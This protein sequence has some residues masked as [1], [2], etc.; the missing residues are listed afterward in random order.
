LAI[1]FFGLALLQLQTLID[2][3]IRNCRRTRFCSNPAVIC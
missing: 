3:I 2:V 1:P